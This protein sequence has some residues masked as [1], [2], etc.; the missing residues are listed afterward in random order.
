MQ[1]ERK[2]G[3]LDLV[4]IWRESNFLMA[5]V[6]IEYLGMYESKDRDYIKE[7]AI[8][9][10]EML[11]IIFTSWN[12][13][14]RFKSKQRILIRCDNKIVESVLISKN[15]ADL[16]L[17][18]GVRWIYMFTVIRKIRFFIKYIWTKNNVIADALSRF[19]P[20][21]A[22]EYVANKT[23]YKINWIRNVCFSDINIYS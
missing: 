10:F 14:D 9:H 15:T 4:V 12:L 1:V 6:P 3:S 16:F 19:D 5:A 23:D 21:E 20:T 11:S 18:Q 2:D 17:M 22:E 7:H 13:R 8:A